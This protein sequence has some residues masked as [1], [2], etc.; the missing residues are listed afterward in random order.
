MSKNA[1]QT[2]KRLHAKYL[3]APIQKHVL[4]SLQRR[5]YYAILFINNVKKCVHLLTSNQKV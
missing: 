1:K 3:K 2:I 5:S 4:T